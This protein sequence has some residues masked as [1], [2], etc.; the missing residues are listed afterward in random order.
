LLQTLHNQNINTAKIMGCL[1][2]V[3]GG[4]PRC[5]GY[6]KRDVSNIRTMLREE[7][8]LKDMSLIVE[9]FEKRQAENPHFLMLRSLTV[10]MRLL[11][12]FGLM[13]GQKPYTRNIKTVSSSIQPSAPIGTTCILLQ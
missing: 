8:T 11:G 13:A 9:Y 4:D 6:V 2:D 3:H 7:V 10:I 1:V 5:L 12:Y